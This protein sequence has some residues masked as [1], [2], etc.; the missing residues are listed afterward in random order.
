M[1]PISKIIM[2]IN[3][4]AESFLASLHLGIIPLRF[5]HPCVSYALFIYYFNKDLVCT[6]ISQAINGT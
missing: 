4:I 6:I 1:K 3:L 5:Y 2:Q